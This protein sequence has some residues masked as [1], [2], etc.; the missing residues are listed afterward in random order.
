MLFR[1]SL[2]TGTM[3]ALCLQGVSLHAAPAQS[4]GVQKKLFGHL[5]TGAA[6]DLYTLT[7][8]HGLKAKIM[9]YGATLTELYTPDR[10]G[11]MGDVVLG[12]DNLADYEKGN[13]YFGATVGRVA[14]RIAK[15]KFTLN[16]KK[17]V[18]AVN[19]PPNHLHGGLKGFDKVI[20]KA[21]SV[22]RPAGPAVEF[23]LHS[24]DGDQGYPGNL[25]V[26]VVYTLTNQNG[27]RIDYRATTDKATP[28]N[29]TN[30]AY[31][32]LAGHGDVLD[33]EIRIDAKKY[34]VVDD[35]SIP[36]GEIRPVADTEMDFLTQHRIGD[37]VERVGGAVTGYDHNYAINGGG[38]KFALAS[39]TYEPT[40]G[41]TM[42]MY[43]TE[44]GMQFYTGNYLDGKIK[45][46]GG[47]VYYKYTGFCIEAGHFPDAVHHP[48][49]PSIILQPGKT[50]TQ[51][52]EYIFGVK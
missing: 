22:Q 52:T 25:D 10:N 38:K 19:N 50:Y 41:R 26:T 13:P 15:G 31:F 12:F 2:L 24:P 33:H 49:F 5:K 11:K 43:T 14:N 34:I 35:V 32:N 45:G 28:I 39:E 37:S 21:K 30:H 36:T 29:L 48:N 1:P 20:W 40:S 4:G 46:V 51:Q 23:T 47:N 44:P 16:G 9:T 6:V 42:T 8:K 3:L 27:M 18:L 7:N 17:Y